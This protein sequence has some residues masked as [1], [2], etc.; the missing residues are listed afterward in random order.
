M[1]T[2]TQQLALIIHTNSE[3]EMMWEDAYMLAETI[4]QAG[5]TPPTPRAEIRAKIAAEICKA[6]ADVLTALANELEKD[7]PEHGIGGKQ[8]GYG[9]AAMHLIT[10]LRQEARDYAEHFGHSH[11][12]DIILKNYERKKGTVPTTAIAAPENIITHPTR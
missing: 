9:Q 5:W 12:T 1:S 11:L 6:K 10:R 7:I 2:S 8:S 4:E 3:P